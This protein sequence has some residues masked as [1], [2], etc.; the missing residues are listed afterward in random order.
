MPTL[1][2][3]FL[4]K[5]G[6]GSEGQAKF[7]ETVVSDFRKALAL[8]TRKANWDERCIWLKDKLGRKTQL[9]P[10]VKEVYDFCRRSQGRLIAIDVETTG[11]QPLACQLI[12]IGMAND[13]G[14]AIC[15]PILKCGGPQ[16]W[17]SGD[18]RRVLECL[19]WLFADPKTHKVFH[20]GSF[21]TTVL[22]A[23]N[24]A[25][26]GWTDDTMQAHHCVDAELPHGLAY[27][28]SRYLEIPYWKDDVK[29]D[30]RWLQLPD[31]TL[32]SY[33]IRDCLAT[34][35]A[36]PLLR[37]ELKELDLEE[38]YFEEIELCKEMVRAT[39]RGIFVDQQRKDELGVTLR[40]QKET[41][42]EFLVKSS[43]NSNFNPGSPAQLQPELF[44]RLK[45]PILK[46]TRTGKPSTDKD[47]MVL[48][49][50]HSKTEEQLTFL[51]HLVKWKK[52][53]KLLSTYVD[54]LP[55]LGDGRL[56]VSWKLLPVTGRFSSSP[57]AQNW[58]PIVKRIFRASEGCKIVG[59][60]LSQ[61]ELR[62][63][64]YYAN[65]A[66]L[67]KAYDEG[68]NV[69]TVNTTLTFG[70]RNPN[71]DTNEATEGYLSDACPL[72]LG[73]SYEDLPTL[74][75]ESWKVAR[76]LAK[77][78]VFGDNYGATAET[79]Y[80]T[81][82]A[83]RNPNTDEL[84]F[85]DVTLSEIEAFKLK[86]ETVLH[87][88]IPAWWKTITRETTKRGHYR[89]P[90]SGRIRFYRGGF[91]RN[92]MLNFPIQ[93]AVGSFMNKR[94]LEMARYVRQVAGEEAGINIQIH[95]FVGVETPDKYVDE[96]KQIQRYCL[97]RPFALPG[98]PEAVLPPD[99]PK[100]TVY[101]GK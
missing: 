27:V 19:R 89:C 48:M 31:E 69:H 50:L 18:K 53:S 7:F 30:L 71:E 83:K 87:P 81:I 66:E 46:R 43:G 100:A 79:L 23:H 11:E 88:A 38:L 29:G 62:V 17:T 85:T 84:L 25:I 80:N 59:A 51:R 93:T 9:F 75:S 64:A 86:W 14:D 99:E 6:D 44:G 73:E 91:K 72:Y 77:N 40:A 33:N 37:A 28:A 16:Y 55:I 45:F 22:W 42:L 10:T 101:L 82:R 94:M 56:H 98:F 12:C 8:Q 20:N 95:D 1:H 58:P 41:S 21:D 3:A 39:I 26:A 32:R 35:R 92:E 67:L 74:D 49:T 36:L 76:T 68:L 61:A 63:I 4:L 60:D 54:G 47:A 96:I 52:A 15:V 57:N 34:I 24:L 5:S 78:E 13:R 97:R 2:P 90:I 65:D 70:V